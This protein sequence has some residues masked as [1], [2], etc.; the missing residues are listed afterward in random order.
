MICDA[1]HPPR[2]TREIIDGSSI[3][4]QG[5]VGAHTSTT[6]HVVNLSVNPIVGGLA[7]ALL[8]PTLKLNPPPP[9]TFRM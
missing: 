1:D 9:T 3:V 2:E 5:S 7:L 4:S 6:A 8:I